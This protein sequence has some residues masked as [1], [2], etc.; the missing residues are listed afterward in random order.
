MA[1]NPPISSD[2]KEEFLGQII[3]I[4]ED[5]LTLRHHDLPCSTEGL[6]IFLKDNDYVYVKEQLQ[7][8]MEKWEII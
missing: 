7:D 8:L 4:F 2:D 3:D 5:W 6:N 1:F